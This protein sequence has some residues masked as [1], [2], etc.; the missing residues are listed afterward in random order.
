MWAIT[1]YFNPENFQSR[2]KNY[3]VFRDKLNIP[4]IT[5]ELSFDNQ[6][7][8][9][10][11]DAEILIQISG[12]SVLWQK[13]RLLNLALQK[14]PQSVENV[15]WIDCDVFFELANWSEMAIDAL[16]QNNIIQLFSEAY[17]LKPNLTDPGSENIHETKKGLVAS[18]KNVQLTSEI[19]TEW[20]EEY[21]PG[22]AWAAKKSL[23]IKHGLYDRLIIGG[24][25]SALAYALYGQYEALKIRHFLNDIR[26][27]NYLEWS[28]PFNSVINSKI[29]YVDQKI[30]HLWHG[31]IENR[32]YYSRHLKLNELGFDPY[33]DIDF[34]DN[35]LWKWTNASKEVRLFLLNYF[36]HRKEDEFFLE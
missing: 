14:I 20:S 8:L 6:F 28:Q 1:S 3:K 34:D 21:H 10:N 23:I 19:P 9:N 27:K 17:Y 7:Q 29:D 31:E 16:R 36:K 18:Y 22:F 30:Y 32:Q 13:E 12:G 2:Y 4:L 11:N 26:Y 15:A 25:D 5:I 33:N 35:G 24:G